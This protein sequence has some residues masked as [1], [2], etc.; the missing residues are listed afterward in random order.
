MRAKKIEFTEWGNEILSTRLKP[1]SASAIKSKPVQELIKS[2]FSK[3]KGVGVGLAA[4]QVN[5]NMQLAV[6]EVTPIPGRPNVSY[7]PKTVII[8]PKILKYSKEKTKGWE[9]CLSCPGI[10]GLVTRHKE[11]RVRYWD[12][13]AQKHEKIMVGFPAIVFQHEIDH[14]NGIRYAERMEDMK[15]L[16]TERELRQRSK[17]KQSSNRQAN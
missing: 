15:M 3:I 4:N 7:F 6:I 9:G 12:E 2:M 1:V 10:R 17:K 13:R 5:K 14:L 11:V 8:N 16:I